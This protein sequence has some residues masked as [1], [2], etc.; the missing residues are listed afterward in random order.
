MLRT[1]ARLHNI[2]VKYSKLSRHIIALVAGIMILLIIYR[3][4]LFDKGIPMGFDSIVAISYAR[5]MRMHKEV[6][7]TSVWRYG[8][9]LGHLEPTKP[10]YQLMLYFVSGCKSYMIYYKL[11][12]FAI[13]CL[14]FISAYVSIYLITHNTLLSFILA[15]TFASSQRIMCEYYSH[16]DIALMIM[17]MP[18]LFYTL[19]NMLL[20]IHSKE[21][22]FL[23]VTL[24]SMILGLIIL[25][26]SIVIV[27]AL[28]VTITYYLLL[29]TIFSIIYCR[30]ITLKLLKYIILFIMFTC[31]LSMYV[32][33]MNYLILTEKLSMIYAFISRRTITYLHAKYSTR[34]VIESLSMILPQVERYVPTPIICTLALLSAIIISL[35]L[36]D[37]YMMSRKCPCKS[38]TRCLII[39]KIIVV[40][41]LVTLSMGPHAPFPFSTFIRLMRTY[42]P[43]F[44]GFRVHTRWNIFHIYLLCEVFARYYAIA[45]KIPTITSCMR[46]LYYVILVSIL[47]LNVIVSGFIVSP[48]CL[49]LCSNKKATLC[50]ISKL[51]KRANTY[52]EKSWY[53]YALVL[54]FTLF[55][56]PR[57]C[58]Y[59]HYPSVSSIRRLLLW[60][61]RTMATPWTQPNRYAERFLYFINGKINEL[62][63]ERCDSST[64][65]LL[66]MGLSMLLSKAGIKYVIMVTSD[67]KVLEKLNSSFINVKI[68]KIDSTSYGCILENRFPT[69]II[70]VGRNAILVLGEYDDIFKA[71]LFLPHE[72]AKN[73][74]INAYENIHI[75]PSTMLEL[76]RNSKFIIVS[77][78]I[79][80]PMLDLTM[81]LLHKYSIK[82]YKYVSMSDKWA[83]ALIPLT[84]LGRTCTINDYCVCLRGMTEFRVPFYISETG[85]YVVLI[86]R[87][88]TPSS[89]KL[90][91]YIDNRIIGN[92]PEK[93]KNFSFHVYIFNVTLCKGN[94]VMRLRNV[95]VENGK[96]Q[97][98]IDEI[99]IVPYNV[100][101]RMY[102]SL[103]EIIQSKILIYTTDR[104]YILLILSDKFYHCK[105]EDILL[106][107]TIYSTFMNQT[108]RSDEKICLFRNISITPDMIGLIYLDIRV[109][110]NTT[111]S[112]IS[113]SNNMTC[114][115]R[116][117][118]RKPGRYLLL[119]FIPCKGHTLDILLVNKVNKATNRYSSLRLNKATLILTK[120][121]NIIEYLKHVV[122]KTHVTY[123][124]PSFSFT[125]S[126]NSSKA[127][128]K[129][130]L[131]H[132]KDSYCI[133]W[134]AKLN[135][136]NTDIEPSLH[137]VGLGGTNLYIWRFN[138]AYWN[139]LNYGSISGK[140][141]LTIQ[142]LSDICLY[143]N[144]L[145]Y[146]GVAVIVF[147]KARLGRPLHLKVLKL[148]R[149]RDKL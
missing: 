101:N 38:I 118:I 71:S 88:N 9:A 30:N 14:T 79:N 4:Y 80:N 112:L 52:L 123:A 22:A 41:T 56:K 11:L 120:D 86:R 84:M 18:L 60:K 129:Y 3:H 5:F 42:L 26:S 98:I 133:F 147:L 93:G 106:N 7:I 104:G 78:L 85:R 47:S 43:F 127:L 48:C 51:V 145:A 46:K 131:L 64:S 28:L 40:V 73:T 124:Y 122:I 119:A 16:I 125:L 113:K 6:S 68:V 105:I 97:N 146:I 102:T 115:L 27:Y 39:S 25:N 111:F 23:S 45:I 137:I 31:M 66:S 77:S 24:A 141:T 91:L 87:Y 74:L 140:V 63:I 29:L 121:S 94:H 21:K 100:Y 72:I 136:D 19:D 95:C 57:K 62:I 130:M 53:C 12:V 142:E 99:E 148:L 1:L 36:T 13:Y 107:G 61:M 58:P 50:V 109:S 69:S 135:V 15:I 110:T 108:L 10:L 33:I 114:K 116:I 70:E 54:P 138:N 17:F 2:K 96:Y 32:F 90:I 117:A 76:I 20:N 149:R 143:L 35:T 89:T 132:F 59:L 83:Y 75:N 37:F 134:S 82:L 126:K 65:K 103:K 92:I 81:L 55:E 34:N 8:D 44:S 128:E 67:H 139:T 49:E 144:L